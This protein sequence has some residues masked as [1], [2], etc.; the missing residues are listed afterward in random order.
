MLTIAG[1]SP[2]AKG[3]FGNL[4]GDRGYPCNKLFKLL[5]AQGVGLTTKIRLRK[6]TL[7]EAVNDQLKKI[8]QIEHSKHHSPINVF[9]HLLAGLTA[10]TWQEKRLALS[11][12]AKD[13]GILNQI[14]PQQK[15]LV[16]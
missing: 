1:W 14:I 15:L 9:V 3:L 4:F 12:T 5:W 6:R 13:S 11:W 8:C 16:A 10:Y 2:I 7:I